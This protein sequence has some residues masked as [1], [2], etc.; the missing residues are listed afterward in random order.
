MSNERSG[1]LDQWR[2]VS[3]LAVVIYHAN[4]DR[5][6]FDPHISASIAESLELFIARLGPLGVDTFFVI[7]GFLITRLLLK[8][9]SQNGSVCLAAF[10]VRRATRI[11]PAMLA[12]VLTV[13][14]A[15]AAG[16][17]RL[18]PMA[19]V[20]AVSF[21]CN[22]SLVTCAYQFGP[23]WTLGVEE[24]FYL[25]WPL[26]LIMSGRFRV[27]LA[28]IT[29]VVAAIC[30]MIPSLVVRDNYNNGLA[31]YCLSSGVLFALSQKFRAFFAAVKRIPPWA[32]LIPLLLVT[33]LCSDGHWKFGHPVALLTTAPILVAVVLARDGNIFGPQLSEALRKV[34]LA[35]YS[36]Y[37][38]HWFA[39]W[40]Y[41]SPLLRGLSVFA[42][43]FAWLSYRY[44]EPPFIAAGQRWSKAIIEARQL[45][46][47]CL[48]K[49]AAT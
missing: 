1:Y 34:G 49:N 7:S 16:L 15:S 17:I 2:G 19:G 30:A 28:A 14:A 23:F 8:E 40:H 31:V 4:P 24:Q 9:E 47:A 36:L 6:L 29:M 33:P 27:P 13:M 41:V 43:P 10:Y 21:L 32:L 35:S 18:E 5:F 22:T 20:K 46:H 48:S 42:V 12:Y 44:I 3:V 11:L 37:I 26:L 25:L 45:N 39:T 38:W